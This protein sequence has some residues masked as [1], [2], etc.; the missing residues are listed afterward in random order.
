MSI[1]NGRDT[2]TPENLR[3]IDIWPRSDCPNHTGKKIVKDGVAFYT[4]GR[5][6]TPWKRHDTVLH[7]LT[8]N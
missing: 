7:E 4:G 6:C 5:K 3:R 2:S 8:V 1:A